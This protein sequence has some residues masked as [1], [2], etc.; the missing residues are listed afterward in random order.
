M[1]KRLTIPQM[2]E[3]L[4]Y[5]QET[6]IFTWKVDRGS[7]V[8]KVAAGSIAGCSNPSGYLMIGMNG[9]TISGQRLAFAFTYGYFPKEVD[10]I[11][12][13]PSDNRI[14]NL[15]AATHQQNI[16]NGKRRINNTSGKKGVHKHFDGRWRA[17]ITVDYKTIHLGLFDSVDD[18]HAAYMHAAKQHYGEFARSA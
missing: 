10:H 15:R 12:G 1:G 16:A 17:R 14:C 18:A 4:G 13:N 7:A 3:I 2:M 5:D 9:R 6:G 11:N 8:S